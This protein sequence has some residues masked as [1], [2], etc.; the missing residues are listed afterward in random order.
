MSHATDTSTGRAKGRPIRVMRVI[1]RM[2]IGG[3]GMHVVL[4]TAG[5]NG[6]EFESVLVTGTVTDN[7]GDMTEF[8]QG[9]GIRPLVLASLRRQVHAPTDLRGLVGLRRL[10][11]EAKP[12]IVHTHTA[13][14]GF[15]GRLAARLSGVPVIV[16]TFHGHVFRGYFGPTETRVYVAMER[17]AARLSDVILTPSERVRKDLIDFRIAPPEKIRVIPLGLPLDGLAESTACRGMLRRELR[18]SPNQRLVGIV[19]RLVPIKRH[20]LFLEA[21][22]RVA[23]SLPDARFVIVGDGERRSRLEALARTLGI[24]DRVCFTGWRRDL[25]LIYAD[26]DALVMSSSNEGTPVSIIEAL[27]AGVP[28]VST[29]VGGVP[30]V[31]RDGLFGRLV[32]AEA[33]QAL[34]AAI[35]DTLENKPGPDRMLAREWVRSRYNSDRLIGDM[36]VLYEELYEGLGRRSKGR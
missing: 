1:T 24:A 12:D 27:A 11:K 32:P 15:L 23:D 22:R 7:E 3:P 17:L 13:K 10:M 35:I 21:A 2:N 25:A 34:A 36:R 26:L 6:G 28:V 9:M 14:A 19:G 33:P 5:L 18:F 4:L 8:A 20:E 29:S 16:H 30:D 31:L